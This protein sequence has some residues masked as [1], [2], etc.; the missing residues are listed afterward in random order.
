MPVQSSRSR[1]H[2]TTGFCLVKDSIGFLAEIVVEIISKVDIDLVRE[3]YFG[4]K[5]Q[6]E[7]L[8]CPEIL[9]LEKPEQQLIQLAENGSYGRGP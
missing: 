7:G 5:V 8:T 9:D 3:T 4:I 6:V 2:G 1:K